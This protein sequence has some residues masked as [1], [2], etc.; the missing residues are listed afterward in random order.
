MRTDR[1]VPHAAAIVALSLR[2]WT[3]HFTSFPTTFG[4]RLAEELHPDWRTEQTQVVT[5]ACTNPDHH[6]AVALA[7]GVV[8]GFG[9]VR[10]DDETSIGEL[11]LLAVDPEVQRHGIGTALNEWALDEMR[12]GGMRLAKVG[13]GGD[14]AHAPARRSYERS[15]YIGIP[16]VHYFQVLD[17][18]QSPAPQTDRRGVWFERSPISSAL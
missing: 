12:R 5:A 13:T 7:N 1:G 16:V 14:D 9:V 10:L 11:H 17:Q 4:E 8:A 6:V 2:A 18:G 3:P 15:G